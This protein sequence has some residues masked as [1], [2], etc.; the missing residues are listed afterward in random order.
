VKIPFTVSP[1]LVDRVNAVLE[2]PYTVSAE[3]ISNALLALVQTKSP[4]E[5][6]RRAEFAA[7]RE[8]IKQVGPY[9]A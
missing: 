8:R 9:E 7:M 3:D 6:I 1:D 2:L 5:A 4:A